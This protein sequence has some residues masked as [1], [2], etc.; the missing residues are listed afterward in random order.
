VLEPGVSQG[1]GDL[2]KRL[3]RGMFGLYLVLADTAGT[4][5][6]IGQKVELGE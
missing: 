2:I 6:S 5:F 4:F 3:I 1:E